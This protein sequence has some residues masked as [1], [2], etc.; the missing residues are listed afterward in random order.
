[1]MNAE[2]DDVGCSKRA[3]KF[4]FHAGRILARSSLNDAE[5]GMGSILLSPGDD[6]A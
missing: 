2:G 6:G 5:V 1:M 3:F 4:R